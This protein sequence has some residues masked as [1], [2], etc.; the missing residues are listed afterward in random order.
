MRTWTA[1]VDEIE[2]SSAGSRPSTGQYEAFHRFPV[3]TVVP[4]SYGPD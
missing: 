2:R 1:K 4:R 3:D